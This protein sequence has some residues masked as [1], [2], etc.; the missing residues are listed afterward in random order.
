[1]VRTS[2]ARLLNAVCVCV[3][4]ESPYML[5]NTMVVTVVSARFS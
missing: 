1:M 5:E 4:V 3:C 2:L